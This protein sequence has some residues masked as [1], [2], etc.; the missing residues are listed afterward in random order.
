MSTNWLTVFLKKIPPDFQGS[1]NPHWTSLIARR[2]AD[3]PQPFLSSR[4]FQGQV[5][6]LIRKENS[7]QG[8]EWCLQVHYI[9]LPLTVSSD[10]KILICFPFEIGSILV[11]QPFDHFYFPVNKVNLFLRIDSLMNKY[12]S[13]ETFLHVGFQGFHLNNCYY[14]Q[15]LQ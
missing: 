10:A 14:Y 13:H 12:S 7:F 5:I 4:L 6:S 8:V 3:L 9:G 2:S 1:I 11:K 15:D